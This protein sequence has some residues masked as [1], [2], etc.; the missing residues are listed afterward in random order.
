MAKS[1]EAQKRITTYERIIEEYGDE[2]GIGRKISDRDKKEFTCSFRM[3]E[4]DGKI[5]RIIHEGN[6]N[7]YPLQSDF[8]RAVTLVGLKLFMAYFKKY[9]NLIS[10]DEFYSVIELEE[11]ARKD[12]FVKEVIQLRDS[13]LK[14]VH[15]RLATQTQMESAIRRALSK[16][17]DA[18]SRKVA[19]E[20]VESS[21]MGLMLEGAGDSDE[22]D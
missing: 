8:L 21:V 11:I 22:R 7:V 5:V 14:A 19:K 15:E 3:S 9:G 17:P 12:D 1:E 20:K 18:M 10:E 4:R 6:K 2:L 16:A 13:Y